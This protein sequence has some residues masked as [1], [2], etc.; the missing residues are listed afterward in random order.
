MLS[1]AA[2]LRGGRVPFVHARVVLAESPT[3]AK[4]GDEAIVLAD[5]SIEG[6]VGGSCVEATLRVQSLLALERRTPALLRVSPIEEAPQEGRVTVVNPCLSGGTLEIFL[7]PVIATPQVAVHGDGPTARALKR[8]GESLGYQMV[9]WDGQGSLASDAVVSASHGRDEEEV[10]QAALLAGVPY[11]ALVASRRRGQAVVES[12]QLE[13][14]LKALVHTP[15]G[16]DLGAQ[17]PAEVALSILAE[18]IS[19]RPRS[20]T[21]QLSKAPA[22]ALAVDPVCGM[23][24]APLETS[25]YL[26]HG[27]ARHFF[28]GPGCLRAFEANPTTYSSS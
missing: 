21:E 7:E 10:L 4:P 5:G 1:R 22:P 3:S 11:V 27:G 24:V 16:L 2:E 17:G 15:A 14:G 28:C 13:P 12:L 26:D 9:D 6:F 20:A 25:L 18:I 23:Q 19:T 8:V